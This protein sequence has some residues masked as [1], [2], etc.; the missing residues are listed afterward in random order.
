LF[1]SVYISF[2]KGIG[3]IAGA[4]LAGDQ[5]FAEEAVIW[6]RRHGGDLI[7]LY[8]YIITADYYY[9]KYSGHMARYYAYAKELAALYNGCHAVRTLPE[10]PVSNMFHVHIHYPKEQVEPLLTEL[11]E[12]TGVALAHYVNAFNDTTSSYEVSLGERFG[13]VPKEKLTQAFERLNEKL[14]TLG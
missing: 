3:G 5:S 10:V 2:Y 12:E 11:T 6:K 14:K 4:I 8:P 1:D 9:E 7:S 13:T